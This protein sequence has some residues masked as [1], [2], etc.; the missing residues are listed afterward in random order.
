MGG[1]EWGAKDRVAGEVEECESVG[2]E[3]AN[4]TGTAL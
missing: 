3:W 4:S 2:A 1:E